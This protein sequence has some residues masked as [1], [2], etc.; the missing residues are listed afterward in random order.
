MALIDKQ[1][2]IL[3]RMEK[4]TVGL[5]TAL[6]A[7]SLSMLALFSQTHLPVAPDYF[8]LPGIKAELEKIWLTAAVE[9]TVAFVSEFETGFPRKAATTDIVQ[10]FINS[11]RP[12]AAQQI[13]ETTQRQVRDLMAGGLASGASA[14]AVYEELLRKIPDL[15]S[16]RA[17]FITRTEVHAASQFTSWQLARQSLVPLT[18][19]WNSIPDRKTRDFGEI[20]PAS[21]FNHRVM[22]G[23]KASLNAAFSVPRRGGGSEQLMFPGD[24]RGSAANVINCRCIQTYE[25]A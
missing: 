18:K 6:N 24:P 5:T 22:D 12:R 25:R 23:Q 8:A 10:T 19:V 11:L 14:D 15:S 16:T 17:L 9:T 2:E 1:L 13:L 21:P 4:D 7:A 3:N 20:G